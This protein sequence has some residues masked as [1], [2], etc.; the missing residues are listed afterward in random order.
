MRS[1]RRIL[2]VAMLCAQ[3][4]QVAE[5]RIINAYE[6]GIQTARISLKHL[7]AMPVTKEVR[8]HLEAVL[9]YIAH[10]I[11][12]ERL[13]DE[14]K[15]ISPSLFHA[16]D[17]IRDKQGRGV[18]VYIKFVSDAHLFREGLKAAT[19]IDQRKHDR[20]A[21]FSKYGANSVAVTVLAKRNALLMLAHEFG[22]ISYVVGNFE[23]YVRLFVRRYRGHYL[24]SWLWGHKPNDPSGQAALAFEKIFQ[25][26]YSGNR[27]AIEE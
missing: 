4:F 23:Q 22:H 19:Q 15:R 26:E 13:L 18:D 12:T 21:C 2:A 7:Q 20:D 3:T 27:V 1:L 10:Y 17:T 25:E 8:C 14:F 11:L 16:I 5:G 6:G 24:E 9:D